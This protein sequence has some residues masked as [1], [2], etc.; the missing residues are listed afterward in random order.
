MKN[1]MI[2]RIDIIIVA[3]TAL[4]LVLA[5]IFAGGRI[6]GTREIS[7]SAVLFKFKTGDTILIDDNPNFSSPEKVEVKNDMLISMSKGTYYWKINLEDES[8][9]IQFTNNEEVGFKIRKSDEGYEVVNAGNNSLNV[10]V[11]EKGV[12]TGKI[13]LGRENGQ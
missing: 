7:S 3:V 13:I 2:Q 10:D 12:M 11:Y 1:K 9:T 6:L 5:A 8:K 4:T